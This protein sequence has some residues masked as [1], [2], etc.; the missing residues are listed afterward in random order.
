MLTYLLL[1][2][3]FK[4]FSKSDATTTSSSSTSNGGAKSGAND[5]MPTFNQFIGKDIGGRGSH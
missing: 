2:V 3:Q 5:E 4:D 1:L